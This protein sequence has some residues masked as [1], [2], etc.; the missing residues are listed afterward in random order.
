MINCRQAAHAD[1]RR[2]EGLR[3]FGDGEIVNDA[4]RRTTASL[5]FNVLQTAPST[6]IK[7]MRFETRLQD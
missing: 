4:Q 6:G 2:I 1:Q 7:S 3:L 5:R